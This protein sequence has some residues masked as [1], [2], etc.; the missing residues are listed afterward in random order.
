MTFIEQVGDILANNGLAGAVIAG[1]A[2]WINRQQKRIDDLTD[3]RH[4]ELLD[5]AN[6]VVPA[7]SGATNAMEANTDATDKLGEKIDGLRT[8]IVSR[9]PFRSQS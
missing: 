2:Y 7:L 4:T 9:G 8:D 5:M 3:K 6:K 1:M